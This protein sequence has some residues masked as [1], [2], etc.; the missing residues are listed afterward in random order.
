MRHAAIQ[1]AAG[2]VAFV[3]AAD[4]RLFGPV[5]RTAVS[6][7]TELK[8]SSPEASVPLESEPEGPQS[9]LA[10]HRVSRGHTEVEDQACPQEFQVHAHGIPGDRPPEAKP[11]QAS[12]LRMGPEGHR[13]VETVENADASLA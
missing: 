4:Y 9:I 8:T 11:L 7:W 3:T 13:S 10:L 12:C 1:F 6:K 2:F 5:P